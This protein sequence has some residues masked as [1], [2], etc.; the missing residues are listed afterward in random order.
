[1]KPIAILSAF[2]IAAL[3]GLA[4]AAAQEKDVDTKRIDKR[5][6]TQERS[7]EK[8]SKSGDLTR[9][10]ANKLEKGQA[11]ID[12][13]EKKAAADG[14]MTKEERARIE[15]MQDRQANQIKKQGSDK[16]ERGAAARQS[17][18]A[19]ATSAASRQDAARLQYD[20]AQ[21]KAM[22]DGVISPREKVELGNLRSKLGLPA[23][24]QKEKIKD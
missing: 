9:K 2:L 21:R 6:E 8:G 1:M 4:G 24:E 19:G 16:Q 5:Q 10:E 7:I 22:E 15:R 14:K 13:A 11:R 17:A 3:P 12:A 23:I 20:A 18:S